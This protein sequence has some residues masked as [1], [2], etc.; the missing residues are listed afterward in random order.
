MTN[1][2]DGDELGNDDFLLE[3][4][5]S[6]PEGEVIERSPDISHDAPKVI[7]SEFVSKPVVKDAPLANAVKLL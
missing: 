7:A 4:A 1:E 2:D 5:I 3:D 6:Q